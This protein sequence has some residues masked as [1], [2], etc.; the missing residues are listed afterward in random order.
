MRT[1]YL[2]LGYFK[3]GS[4]FLQEMWRLN[5]GMLCQQGLS[6]HVPPKI[7]GGGFGK[8]T[9][10]NG[11]LALR[12]ATELGEALVNVTQDCSCL[13][14]SEHFFTQILESRDLSFIPAIASKFGFERVKSLLLVRDPFGLMSSLYDQALKRAGGAMTIEEFY[15]DPS[16]VVTPAKTL[17]VIEK[18]DALEGADLEVLNYS[19]NKKRIL[20][21]SS[22]WLGIDSSGFEKP[23]VQT[24][25]RSLNSGERELLRQLNRVKARSAIDLSN[26]LCESLPLIASDQIAPS[27]QVQECFLAENESV[28]RKIQERLSQGQELSLELLTAP[29][30][31][32]FTFTREQ[33]SVL[34]EYIVK[35]QKKK[36]FF[37]SKVT[38]FRRRFGV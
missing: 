16:A 10:G 30:S 31:E 17:T 20:E 14:S 33:L 37:A 4:S 34:V 23:E 25:N 6:Y 2:H 18:L 35:Y 19:L 36:G 11:G 27:E 13:L 1:L 9:S 26:S 29:D 21:A 28:F 24:V 7:T 8:I 3:T 15:H 22:E 32:T 12:G 38:S 5:E